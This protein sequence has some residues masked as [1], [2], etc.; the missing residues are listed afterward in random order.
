MGTVDSARMIR[1]TSS[2][3]SWGNIRSSST[4]PG[5][6][7]RNRSIAAAPSGATIGRKPSRSSVYS[8]LSASEGSSSTIRT[9]TPE[10]P[11]GSAV[12]VVRGVGELTELSGQQEPDLLGDVHGVVPNPFQLAGH[13]VH[14]DPPL[15]GGGVA[16]AEGQDLPVQVPVQHV[17]W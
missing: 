3:D 5:R 7:V 14:P 9:R 2:P 10:A 4:R 17:H 12:A 13:H 8:M 16:P 6:S 11:A 15:E 1:H